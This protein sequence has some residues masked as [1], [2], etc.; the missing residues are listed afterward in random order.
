MDRAGV[1]I[2]GAGKVTGMYLPNLVASEAIELVGVG[3]VSSEAAQRL[4]ETYGIP[5]VFDGEALL[6]SDDVDVVLN[7]TPMAVHY[8]TNLRILEAGKHVYSEKPLG[9]NSQEAAA[10]V[11]AAKKAGLTVACA[12]D[13]L[14]GSGFQ[15]GRKA[16]EDGVIGEPGAVYASML[17]P[18]AKLAVHREGSFPIFD[19][20]PYY[21]SALV[22]LFGPAESLSATAH[23]GVDEPEIYSAGTLVFPGGVLA[24]IV[25]RYGGPF[26]G[27]I[28]TLEIQGTEGILDM[29]NPDK[30]TQ[31]ARWHEYGAE[32]WSEAGGDPD[33]LEANL[34]G[35]GL[36]DM[37][38]AI[39]DGREPVASAEMAVH[40]AEIIDAMSAA[41]TAEASHHVLTTTFEKPPLVSD[42]SGVAGTGG[43]L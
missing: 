41:T 12:P 10:V 21:V 34:R 11:E 8:E 25:I 17:R 27:E 39:R 32:D 1:G 6:E 24:S 15:A 43:S 13:T 38:F 9:E 37:I 2:L 16:L 4:A 33:N 36:E 22:S 23:L 28:S 42:V 40:V 7:L 19:M 5:K 35:I 3:D 14:L 31:P 30:F 26:P 29:P 18:L 20:A